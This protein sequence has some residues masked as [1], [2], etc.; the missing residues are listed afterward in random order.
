MFFLASNYCS[1]L[2]TISSQVLYLS[3]LLQSVSLGRVVS[4]FGDYSGFSL[5]W[6]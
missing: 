3:R 2:R 6:L 4:A 5:A 1:I